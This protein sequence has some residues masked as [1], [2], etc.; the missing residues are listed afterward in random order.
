MTRE[1]SQ[2]EAAQRRGQNSFFDN[3]RIDEKNVTNQEDLT[4][5]VL[6]PAHCSDITLYAACTQRQSPLV[7][8]RNLFKSAKKVFMFEL[9]LV[10]ECVV[11]HMR[12]VYVRG[13]ASVGL[14]TISAGS[15]CAC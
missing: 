9:G 10:R 4:Y 14:P 13:T 2:T 8:C 6:Q 12:S 5:C 7:T 1:H 11:V 3:V 15:R